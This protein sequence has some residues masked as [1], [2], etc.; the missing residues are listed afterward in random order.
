MINLQ[1]VETAKSTEVPVYR[2]T[3]IS[4]GVR[5]SKAVAIEMNVLQ[6]E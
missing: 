1:L 3:T 2:S 5:C 6:I 4:Q